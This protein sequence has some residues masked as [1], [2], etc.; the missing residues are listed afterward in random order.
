MSHQLPIRILIVDDQQ[1]IRSLCTAVGQGMGLRCLHATGAREALE[2][3]G[4]DAP[5]LMLADLSMGKM[6]DLELLAEVKRRAPQTEVALVSASGSSESAFEAMRLG[7]YDFVVK[8][9]G[10]ERIRLILERMVEKV[11]L[12]RENEYL[13]KVLQSKAQSRLSPKPLCTDL[14]ELERQTV[15]RVFEQVH[16]NKEQA[17]KLLGISRATLYRKIKR[18][19]IK[20]RRRAP[21]REP[22]E[23]KEQ[24]ILLSQS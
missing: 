13:R 5:E 19:G 23:A 12:V 8:P 18:Y 20:A 17:Q 11:R 15:R 10:E 14:E 7:A 2:Q 3:V 24:M 9:F 6:S 22:R 21:K 1:E 16:G 4:K